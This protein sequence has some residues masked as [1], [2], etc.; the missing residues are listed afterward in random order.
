MKLCKICLIEQPV[1]N[2][3]RN[4]QN[5]DKLQTRC[6]KCM[7]DYKKVTRAKPDQKEKSKLYGIKYKYNLSPEE[8]YELISG[9]CHSC[10]SHD[11]IAVDHDHSCCSGKTTCGKCIRGVLCR[12][13]NTVEGILKNSPEC[14]YG[15]VQYMEKHKII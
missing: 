4:Y 12:R 15:L 5:K 11:R 14:L 9:G 1:T 8:Y 2:F 6:K 13:C 3:T 7:S 10:G